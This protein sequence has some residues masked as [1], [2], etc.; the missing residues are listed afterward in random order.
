MLGFRPLEMKGALG[1]EDESVKPNTYV[2]HVNK[3]MC[4]KFVCIDRYTGADLLG[5][6]GPKHTT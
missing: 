4:N 3:S 6:D 2:K 5:E 1:V